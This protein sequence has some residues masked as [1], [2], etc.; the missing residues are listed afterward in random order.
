MR[1]EESAAFVLNHTPKG[2][3]EVLQPENLIS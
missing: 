3:V 2:E 1:G